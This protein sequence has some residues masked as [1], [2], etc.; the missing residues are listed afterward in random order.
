MRTLT[1][2]QEAAWRSAGG[3]AHLRVRIAG[4]DGLADWTDLIGGQ[5]WIE[6]ATWGEGDDQPGQDGTITTF[7]RRYHDNASPFVEAGQR[8]EGALLTGA[9][10]LIDVA[11]MPDDVT[12]SA[13]D[14]QTVMDAQID[15]IALD[16]PVAQ[17][18]LRD[19]IIAQLQDR[20]IEEDRVYG[21]PEGRPLEHV[22]QDLLDDWAGSPAQAIFTPVTPSFLITPY[23]A[24]AGPLLDAIGQLGDVIGWQVR[25]RWAAGS[26]AFL[27]ALT[28]P[29]RAATTPVFTFLPSEI[30][31]WGAVGISIEDVRNAVEVLYT[32]G[33][34]DAGG[35]LVVKR[36]Y[37]E[38][39]ASQAKYGRRWFSLTEGS[40]SQINTLAEAE[41]LAEA[42]LSDLAEP[43]VQVAVDVPLIWWLELGDLVRIPG[44]GER[45]GTNQDLAIVGIRHTINA[46]ETPKTT[47]QLYGKPRA[48]RRNWMEREARPGVAPGTTSRT[49]ATPLPPD[50]R[51]LPNAVEVLARWPGTQGFQAL[52]F[53]RSTTP[54]FT[55]SATTLMQRG[56]ERSC[57]DALGAED[58]T[59]YYKVVV[60]DQY[61]NRS[62][63]SAQAIGSLSWTPP[64]R[65]AKAL[66]ALMMAERITSDQTISASAAEIVQLNSEVFDPQGV[67][68][69]GN[70]RLVPLADGIYKLTLDLRVSFDA[71]ATYEVSLQTDG[72]SV[73]W[74][75]GSRAAVTERYQITTLVELDGGTIHHLRLAC[76]AGTAYVEIGSTMI[77]EPTASLA[78]D[79]SPRIQPAL[80][81]T[82]SGT[83]DG[84]TGEVLTC[85][86]GT[87]DASPTP[88]YTYQWLRAG[89]AIGGATASTYTLVTADLGQPIA[90]VVTATNRAG[91]GSAVASEVG[92]ITVAPSVT[93][94]P[95]VTGDTAVGSVLTCTTGTWAGAPAPTYTYQWWRATVPDVPISGETGNTYTTQSADIGLDVYCVVT[96]TNPLGS[97]SQASNSV[98]PID[99]GAVAPVNTVAPVVS[100]TTT[101]GQTLACSE[102]TWTGT[103][104]ITYAYIW[105]SDDG[106]LGDIVGTDS[107]TYTLQASDV[108]NTISCTVEAT[109]AAGAVQAVSNTVGPIA[110]AATPPVNTVAPVASGVVRIGE[111]LSTTDGTW[112]GTPAPTYA[113]QWTRDGAP[114]GGATSAT[115]TVVAA[116]MACE[117]ACEVTATN[118]AGS[119]MEPSNALASPWRDILVAR[120]GVLIWDGQDP[121]CYGGAGVGAPVEELYTVDG[122]LLA[123]QTITSK[124]ATRTSGGTLDFDGA[125]DLYVGSAAYAAY[126]QGDCTYCLGADG[127]TWAAGEWCLH[128]IPSAGVASPYL[129]HY[130]GNSTA[131]TRNQARLSDVGAQILGLLGA[132]QDLAVTWRVGTP[133]YGALY[134]LAG[135]VAVA[136]SV[137]VNVVAKTFGY[138]TLGGNNLGTTTWQG[139]LRHACFD[140]SEWSSVE[141]DTYRACAI[142]AGVM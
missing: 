96:A 64:A 100:G 24:S 102:G 83:T 43:S 66:S 59:T 30:L 122:L 28:E 119:A 129:W 105:I 7:W 104:P 116:D 110:S 85:S 31:N 89:V 50:V 74:S 72:L 73:V 111:L 136:G 108:G 15:D 11:V 106:L 41:A 92:P 25:P 137:T 70:Y 16:Y 20:W 32:D 14:W 51:S 138:W 86:T 121:Y 40:S 81:P 18:T 36:A 99:S 109:N 9:R 125:D 82:I 80:P 67:W 107:P 54:D 131:I 94:D 77:C 128:A 42:I 90:C 8:L 57:M 123:T 29:D 10:V 88:T 87:W 27:L 91:K 1:P 130:M 133:G 78:S 135:G 48:G 97:A 56:L 75:S 93:A 53:H 124:R 95:V 63:P 118:T 39:L 113:Y 17:I 132:A 61:G 47:L 38:D 126:L 127:L 35:Q 55:P 6:S 69:A 134:D 2:A 98:G 65:L 37:A 68:S 33:S 44:D 12:P 46:Q 84:G 26:G 34:K 23:N 58:E 5:G 140:D 62:A 52:E 103:L 114:I 139:N 3:V 22:I 71:S 112:T 60:V 4:V 13:G 79:T 19:R 49:P 101:E 21:S 117:I 141:I 115:Y 76:N 45:F 120:P 142:A